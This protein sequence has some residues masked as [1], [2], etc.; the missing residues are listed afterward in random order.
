MKKQMLLALSAGLAISVST[1]TFANT[2]SGQTSG[3]TGTTITGYSDQSSVQQDQTT[4]TQGQ[5]DTTTSKFKKKIA[6]TTVAGDNK[7]AKKEEKGKEE[8]KAKSET[9]T[10]TTTSTETQKS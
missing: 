5:T 10:D 8:G 4:T 7:D 2:Q 1:M 9:K 6:E 3:S